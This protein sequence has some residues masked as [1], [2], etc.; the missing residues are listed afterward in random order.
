M[1]FWSV[2]FFQRKDKNVYL[3]VYSLL[4]TETSMNFFQIVTSKSDY[5]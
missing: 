2:F 4:C 1:N 5:K 3:F